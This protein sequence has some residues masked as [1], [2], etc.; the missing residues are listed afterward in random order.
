VR[1]SG[2]GRRFFEIQGGQSLQLT[3]KEVTD[4]FDNPKG[5]S[6]RFWQIYLTPAG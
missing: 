5:A 4:R 6:S 2:S 3:E 1:V